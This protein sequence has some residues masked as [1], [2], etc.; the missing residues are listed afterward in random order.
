MATRE[1][2]FTLFGDVYLRFQSFEFLQDFVSGIQKALPIKI[3]IG[4]IYT[5]DVNLYRYSANLQPIEKEVVFDIDLNDYDP[6]RT[7]CQGPAV[8]HKC[9]KFM[10]IACQILDAGLRE[11]F[12]LHQLLWVF[13]GRRG[14]HCWVCDPK[15]KKFE[16]IARSSV[17]EH[18]V[19]WSKDKP[20]QIYG[21]KI[22]PAIMLV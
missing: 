12:N 9:W 20:I 18:F 8:C 5:K 15:A 16:N 19:V 21:D 11:E 14:I 2:S 6:V 10:V 1:L 7:C 17:A 4:S 3:D 13:S 22:H